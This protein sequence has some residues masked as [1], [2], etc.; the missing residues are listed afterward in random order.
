MRR[1]LL[2]LVASGLMLGSA[3]PGAGAHVRSVR[4]GSPAHRAGLLPGDVVLTAAGRDVFDDEDLSAALELPGRKAIAVRR[5]GGI[6]V[7]MMSA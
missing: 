1:L 2:P 6:N 4:A 3:A 7:L 5:D